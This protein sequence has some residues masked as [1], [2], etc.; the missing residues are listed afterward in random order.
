MS[1]FAVEVEQLTKR[2]GSTV[3]LDGVSLQI[4]TGTVLG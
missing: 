1:E 4:P 3:A 2:F